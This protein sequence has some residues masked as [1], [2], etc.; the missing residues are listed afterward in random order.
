[1]TTATKHFISWAYLQVLQTGTLKSKTK[2]K[3]K[4]KKRLIFFLGIKCSTV[5]HLKAKKMPKTDL[6][7]HTETADGPI[8][9]ISHQGS[10]LS[11]NERS[12]GCHGVNV[13]HL[14]LTSWRRR[15]RQTKTDCGG[16]NQCTPTSHWSGAINGTTPTRCTEKVHKG[17]W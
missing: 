6:H 9:T 5:K 12:T 2:F 3:K 1:M 7:S 4:K 17:D 16:S 10:F 11:T 14:P 13:V 15:W 8:T